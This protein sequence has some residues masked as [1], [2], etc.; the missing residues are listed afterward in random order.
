MDVAVKAMF[1][2]ESTVTIKERREE[3]ERREGEEEKGQ[4]ISLSRRYD[5]PPSSKM[6]LGR[7]K[8]GKY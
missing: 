5:F 3:R 8:E 1:N 6:K 2:V 4:F 7:K